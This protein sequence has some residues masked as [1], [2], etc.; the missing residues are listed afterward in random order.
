MIDD[1]VVAK[2]ITKPAATTAPTVATAETNAART[3]GDRS[4]WASAAAKSVAPG[5]AW[6]IRAPALG[7]R[8]GA[9]SGAVGPAGAV[10]WTRASV[11]GD[12]TPEEDESSSAP[13]SPQNRAEGLTSAPHRGHRGTVGADDQLMRRRAIH[14][15][16][17]TSEAA[18]STEQEIGFL[19]LSAAS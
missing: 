11:S 19:L 17:G 10:G 1:A 16:R 5:A 6:S 12:R 13:Q 15:A 7:S 18:E 3:A 2:A 9:T 14:R 4:C 8:G